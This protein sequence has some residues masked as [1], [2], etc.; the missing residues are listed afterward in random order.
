MTSSAF[1]QLCL[2]GTDHCCRC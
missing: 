1:S 2:T